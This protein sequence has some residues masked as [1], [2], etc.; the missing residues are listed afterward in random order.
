MVYTAGSQALA[1][2]EMLVHLDSPDLLK[3]YRLI[4]VT[5]DRS[6]TET[7]DVQ[8]LPRDWRRHPAP[9]SVRTLGDQ[10]V[11]ALNTPVLEV[12]SV[13]VPAERNYLLN[14]RHPRFG[15][16]VIGKPQPYRFDVR[17]R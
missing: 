3:H 8:N 4:P 5:F 11:N 16:I 9:R 17:L 12:P 14:V 10:W 15:E 6:L 2:L 1:V 13:I 7:L